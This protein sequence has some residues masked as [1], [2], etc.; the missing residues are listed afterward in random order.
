MALTRVSRHIIDEPLEL[1]NINATGI[2][3]FASLRVTGD[4][5]VDGTTTTLDTVVTEVDRLEVSAN[6]S[7]V[8]AAI[9]QT[10]SGDIL[11]LFDGTSE[12]FSVADGGRIS[13]GSIG[14]LVAAPLHIKGEY[15]DQSPVAGI[16][17]G[18]FVVSNSDPRYGINFGVKQNGT[19][20][21]QQT[22]TEGSATNY[23]LLLNPLG[24]NIGIGTDN[25]D[26][27]LVVSNGGTSSSASGGTLARI[28]GSGVARLDIVAGNSNHSILEFSRAN[29]T[30]AGQITYTHS[31]NSLSFTANG[32][33]EKL[34]ITSDGK[35]RVPDNGKFVAGAGD[36]LQIYHTGTNSLIVNE[37]DSGNLYLRNKD[38]DKDIFLQI[39]PIPGFVTD[40]LRADGSTGEVILYASGIQKLSTKS[41]GIDVTGQVNAS[42][43]HLTDG[44]GIHIGNSNDLRF[45]HNGTNSYIENYTGNLYIFNASNDRDIHL[46]TDDGS[47]GV[48]DYVHCDGSTGAVVLSH[49]GNVKLTTKSDG[50][51]VT[52]EVQCDSLD[53]DGGFNIDG[54]QITY[55]ATS[56]I[57]K[58]TDNASLYFGSGNDL[59]IYHD[60]SHSYIN[61]ATA[62]NLYI[63]HGSETMIGAFTDGKV[64]LRYDNST[65]FETTTTGAKVTGA[66]EVTQ[67]YPSIRPTLDL[68]F[69]ATKSLDRRITFT[70]DSL[71]TYTDENGLVKYA[72]NNVPRF[73]HDPATGE[74][75]GLLIEESRTNLSV[76]SNSY[77]SWG[78]N[79]VTSP[80]PTNN[81]QI[82][83]D[84]TQTAW[85]F[86]IGSTSNLQRNY[87]I[88][89]G[90]TYTFSFFAKQGSGTAM[91]T[92][93]IGVNANDIFTGT[94]YNWSTNTLGSGWSKVD[95]SNGWSRFYRTFTS[96]TSTLFIQRMDSAYGTGQYI[97]GAQLEAGSFPTSYIPTSGSTVTRDDDDAVIKG[98]NF[99]DIYNETEG[100]IFA[101]FNTKV[102]TGT[103][104]KWAVSLKDPAN[105]NNY[106]AVKTYGAQL[107]ALHVK[108]GGSAVAFIDVDNSVVIDQFR[109]VAGSFKLNDFDAADGGTLLT[110]DTSGAMPTGI[111]QMDIGRGWTN[112]DQKLEGHIKSI[113]Y[114]RTKLPDAQLQGLTQQ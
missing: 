62:G 82:S 87:A 72:S 24:G 89:A 90:Q 80:L 73:D 36:D 49:Y 91:G 39:A 63:T 56:N 17:S 81:T 12:V 37:S 76:Y 15:L 111:T 61:Q 98:T 79:A 107:N 9:T 34:R 59:R 94:I 33:Q 45:Y 35:V 10:G 71:G 8:G 18:S 25:P 22:R 51:D 43:M 26:T 78:T 67:E 84:G 1:Q 77:T 65:K 21:I 110:G 97:W 109:R 101:E 13:V 19:G 69:A 99:S 30:A 31:D 42:T 55:D 95:Y 54:S 14:S 74:S 105:N 70:R 85:Q 96:S 6:N 7:T 4:L 66:L 83:P 86:P 57:M 52:G 53:V 16:G 44:N 92:D 113:K 88:T 23:P 114:Y 41:T 47:G 50:I 48:A 68:N 64:E 100:T 60:G 20:W 108:S 106:I 75:L 3:T 2:G 27:K 104:S 58:F 103:T 112:S 46:S 102:N 38:A 5:Q 40:Y 93:V 28:V 29:L 11:R 32:A